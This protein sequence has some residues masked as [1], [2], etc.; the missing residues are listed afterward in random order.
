M[1]GQPGVGERAGRQGGPVA[2]VRGRGVPGHAAEDEGGCGGDEGLYCEFD[3]W[4]LEECWWWEVRDD[5]R[6]MRAYVPF[7]LV[8]IFVK[9]SE[10]A[11][12]EYGA[13]FFSDRAV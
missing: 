10:W 11:W 13:C 9:G 3:G 5:K 4:A 6:K 2:R 8:F 12:V 1:D 7:F